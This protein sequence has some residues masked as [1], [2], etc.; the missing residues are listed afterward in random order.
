MMV[1]CARY[2]WCWGPCVRC[3]GNVIIPNATL[4][5]VG[6]LLRYWIDWLSVCTWCLRHGR[7]GCCFVTRAVD[8]ATLWRRRTN[9]LGTLVG[10]PRWVLGTTVGTPRIESTCAFL[11]WIKPCTF[12]KLLGGCFAVTLCFAFPI[13]WWRTIIFEYGCR[14]T[15]RVAFSWWRTLIKSKFGTDARGDLTFFDNIVGN[16]FGRIFLVS[17]SF[18]NLVSFVTLATLDIVRTYPRYPRYLPSTSAHKRVI[19][20]LRWGDLHKRLG[21]N[22]NKY[23]LVLSVFLSLPSSLPHHHFVVLAP[24]GSVGYFRFVTGSHHN[25]HKWSRLVLPPN[26]LVNVAASLCPSFF[27]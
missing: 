8:W 11:L 4:G 24:A 16:I 10:V 18:E 7:S 3:R 27:R 17:F 26:L 13:S 23:L 14:I 25:F 22:F 5:R 9:L 15:L 12:G 2:A 20:L 19:G 1:F 21:F 6:R